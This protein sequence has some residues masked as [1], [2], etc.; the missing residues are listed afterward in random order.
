MFDVKHKPYNDVTPY[1]YNSDIEISTSKL[2]NKMEKLKA[3]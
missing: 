1:R 3:D 2:K